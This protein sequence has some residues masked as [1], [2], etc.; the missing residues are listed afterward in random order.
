MPTVKIWNGNHCP[1]LGL[2]GN[3]KFAVLILWWQW[4]SLELSGYFANVSG[5]RNVNFDADAD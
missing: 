1:R 5:H 4:F 2:G 3:C